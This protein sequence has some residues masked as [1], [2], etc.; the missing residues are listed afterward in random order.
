MQM[1]KETVRK[2]YKYE[3]R[4]FTR[5]NLTH[6]GSV[7]YDEYACY[8]TNTYNDTRQAWK[9][10]DED[11][12]YGYDLS[13][14]GANTPVPKTIV[15]YSPNPIHVESLRIRNSTFDG[16]TGRH[17]IID[18]TVRAAD[19]LDDAINGNVLAIGSNSENGA[20]AYW[21][22]DLSEQTIQVDSGYHKYWSLTST[23]AASGGKNYV[24]VANIDFIDATQKVP[25]ESTSSNY[26]FY[27]DFQ[28]YKA[29]QSGSTYKAVGSVGSGSSSQL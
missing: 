29:V 24:A 25:V 5:P 21:D 4:P 23:T 8:A 6:N 16:T 18:Y 11:T 20:G 22:I 2:Y 27:K 17:H 28:I 10:F 19:S 26:D 15:F 13:W 12:G 7:G 1:V 9:A 3:T 14:M